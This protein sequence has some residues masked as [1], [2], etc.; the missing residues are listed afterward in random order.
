MSKLQCTE[1][2]RFCAIPQVMAIATLDKCYANPKVF[3]GVV[4][5]RKGTSCKLLLR[6]NSLDEVH[7]TFYVFAKSIMSTAIKQKAA[8]VSDPSHQRTLKA[9]EAIMKW[10]EAAYNRQTKARRTPLIISGGLLAVAG[11]LAMT[12]S[13]SSTS[14]L[15]AALVG[16]AGLVYSFGFG[17]L[18]PPAALK[19]ASELGEKSA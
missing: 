4:K 1:I 18:R 8:G 2:F 16:T 5:I 10:T 17:M 3:T 6:T 11:G 7:E 12:S 19:T 9:C 15:R 13:K 14:T